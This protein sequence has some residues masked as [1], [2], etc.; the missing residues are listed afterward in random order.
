MAHSRSDSNGSISTLATFAT[1]KSS[2]DEEDS[3]SEEDPFELKIPYSDSRN[4]TTP[5]S[6]TIAPYKPTASTPI[7]TKRSTFGSL[8]TNTMLNDYND[9]GIARG[10]GSYD[11]DIRP[12]L[13]NRNLSRDSAASVSTARSFPLST[14]PK[15]LPDTSTPPGTAS[16]TNPHPIRSTSL[17][18]NRNHRQP[19]PVQMLSRDDQILVERLVASLGKC[20]LSLQEK[21]AGSYDSRI[22]RRRLDAARRVLEG[23]EGA[24]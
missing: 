10:S 7:A 8:P 3:E 23:E 19:S 14:K 18:N 5:D 21:D 12:S 2:I 6:P 17:E 16:S 13:H 24:I 15:E 20:V 11:I 22:W 1:A 4:A 9:I